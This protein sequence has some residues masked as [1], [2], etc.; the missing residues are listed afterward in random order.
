MAIP[1]KVADSSYENGFENFA[2][3]TSN[4]SK[5]GAELHF[6]VI[7]QNDNC[8]AQTADAQFFTAYIE[9]YDPTTGV[10]FGER[11]VSIIVPG[12]PSSQIN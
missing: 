11:K 8:V 9:V 7:A 10:S 3:G 2:P 1:T 12:G 6:T 5:K 4:A